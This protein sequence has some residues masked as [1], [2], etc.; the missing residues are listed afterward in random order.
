[1][2]SNYYSSCTDTAKA[3]YKVDEFA[4]LFSSTAAGHGKICCLHERKNELAG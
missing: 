3:V 1:M 2:D 4:F